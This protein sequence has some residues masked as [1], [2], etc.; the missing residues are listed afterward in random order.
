MVINFGA[1]QLAGVRG[2]SDLITG[3]RQLGTG[4]ALMC[5]HRVF[6]RPFPAFTPPPATQLASIGLHFPDPALHPL[7]LLDPFGHAPCCSLQRFCHTDP[8]QLHDD[9]LVTIQNRC[10]RFSQPCPVIN[11]RCHNNRR[12]D[13]TNGCDHVPVE[14]DLS[15]STS[16]LI[17]DSYD[18]SSDIRED[19]FW[20]ISTF[21]CSP[22]TQQN[23]LGVLG[24]S[25]QCCLIG[26]DSSPS[27][28]VA[29]VS[30]AC[31]RRALRIAAI[32]SSVQPR[33]AGVV[34]T[35]SR[36]AEYSCT[37]ASASCATERVVVS[38]QSTRTSTRYGSTPD[39]TATISRA[40]SSQARP[41]C[42]CRAAALAARDASAARMESADVGASVRVPR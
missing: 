22:G 40:T 38:A 20:K 31:S 28:S 13:F 37:A 26:H 33:R 16:T 5:W 39:R 30:T 25:F 9:V 27:R 15:S 8:F 6:C 7:I 24:E 32:S 21:Y 14:S 29:A 10:E 18:L 11:N 36:P 1:L 41:N 17:R 23:V 42:A 12:R 35:G 34:V 3:H 4:A 19:R 2:R